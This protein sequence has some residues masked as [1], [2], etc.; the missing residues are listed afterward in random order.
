MVKT[1]SYAHCVDTTGVT[2][3]RVFEAFG[4]SYK[5]NVTLGDAVYVVVRVV[6]TYVHCLKDEGVENIIK[7]FI[8]VNI[9]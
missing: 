8:I 6:N 9:E 2:L 5:K 4:A 7:C 1:G 3:E